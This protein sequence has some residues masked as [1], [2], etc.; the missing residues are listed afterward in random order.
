MTRAV[1][2]SMPRLLLSQ[3]LAEKLSW[4]LRERLVLTRRLA[5]AIQVLHR[6]GQT[7]RSLDPATITL[8]EQFQPQLGPPAGP[9][10]FGGDQSD[11]EFCPPELA[12]SSVVELPAEIEVAAAILRQRGIALDPRRID[13]YQLGVLLCQLL[14]GEPFLNYLYSPTCK[15]KVPPMTRA[16]LN[17]CLGESPAGPLADCDAMVAAL[18]D[19]IRQ[20]PQDS[21]TSSLETPPSGSFVISPGN[22]PPHGKAVAL[23]AETPDGEKLPFQ[24][25]GHFQIVSQIGSGG[26]GDVYR[27]YDASLD[28]YVAIK[29]LAEAL[30]RDKE[31][32][33]RFSAEATAVAKLSHPNVVP[34]Y[35]I[36]QDARRHF[37]AMQFIEGQSLAERLA[38]D[39][40]LPVDE[41][42][43]IIEQC[44][45]GLGA[46]HAQGLIHRDV[47]P[48]NILLERAS[49]RAVLVDFGLVRHLNAESRMTATGVVMGTVDYLAPEQARGRA[50]DG[51][52]DIY[53]VG[54]MFY[55]LLGGR[56]P[57]IADSPT[58]MIFQHAYETPFPLKKAAPDVPQSLVDVTARM[59]A[60]EPAERYASCDAVLADLRAFREGRPVEAASLSKVSATSNTPADELP[61]DWEP[62]RVLLP[63]NNPWQRA[64]DWAATMFRRHAPQYVQEM[65]DTTQQM[66]A[67]VAHYE[68]RCKRL[69]DL[70]QE[71][72][73]IESDLSQQINA[74]LAVAASKHNG[75]T[76]QA[77]NNEHE[78][79]VVALRSQRDVQRQQVEE[80]ERQLGKAS[81]TLASLHSQQN[82]L[83]SRL[84][85]AEARR[86]LEGGPI[87]RT[88]RQRLVQIAIVACF[89]ALLGSGLVALVPGA[90]KRLYAPEMRPPEPPLPIEVPESVGERGFRGSAGPSLAVGGLAETDFMAPTEFPSQWRSHRAFAKISSPGRVVFPTLPVSAYVFEADVTS[91]NPAGKLTFHLGDRDNGTALVMGHMWDHV[92]KDV[93]QIRCRLFAC[94]PFG[95]NWSGGHDYEPGTRL[96]L[97]IVVPDGQNR[98]LY[99]NGVPTLCAAGV[100]ADLTLT[101]VAEP[102]ADATIHRCTLRKLDENDVKRLGLQMPQRRIS[103]DFDVAAARLS[104]ET[105]AL[106]L[107][108]H[109]AEAFRV[110]TTGTVMNWISPGEFV[111]GSPHASYEQF[112]KGA[113]RVRFT[114][115]YWIGRYQVM[116]GEWEGLMGDNPSRVQ[117][118]PCLPVNW[119]SWVDAARFCRKLTDAEKQ[120]GRIPEGYEYR[121]P[122]EA[123]WEYACLAGAAGASPPS[124][125]S[126]SAKLSKELTAPVWLGELHQE[127]PNAWGLCGMLGSVPE[128]CAD[129]WRPY[130]ADG[131][132]R[133]V[134]DRF[135]A[136]GVDVDCFVV[137]GGPFD[138]ITRFR[139]APM[140]AGDYRGFR[141]VLGPELKLW[142]GGQRASAVAQSRQAFIIGNSPYYQTLTDM[143]RRKG[144]TVRRS[145]NTQ[146][147]ELLPLAKGHLLLVET[148][149]GI[150]IVPL[151]VL[152][153]VFPGAS[154]GLKTS[155][156]IVNIG[157]TKI[158][159]VDFSPPLKGMT[160]DSASVGSVERQV[161]VVGNSPYYETLTEMAQ[162]KGMTVVS[163]FNRNYDTW[164]KAAQGHILLVETHDGTPV[165]PLSF[166]KKFYPN[167]VDGLKTPDGIATVENTRIV[168]VDFSRLLH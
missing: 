132:T 50:V 6:Q 151:P 1:A 71:A 17:S 139:A 160:D 141:L 72:R 102:N 19:L 42:V 80:L 65:Q 76:A 131:Q 12:Q 96:Q 33:R 20:L 35:F 105:V 158:V 137:R 116:Q 101:I 119:I 23:P 108:A 70:L 130:P 61:V 97:K 4:S 115:G 136:G 145:F 104:R 94:Q 60:K 63:S 126:P 36:G 14:T 40:R 89:F 10:R 135:E 5:L 48:G 95:V 106:G 56:L 15:A 128:W 31:F 77:R 167:A 68:R 155:D 66:D 118:S 148:H 166:L 122:T 64:R 161:F 11:P 142:D 120:H 79:D 133:V 44:L 147:D 82:V 152:D 114:K 103:P 51:R 73:G 45:A 74:Q 57:F 18:D 54:V 34:I 140:V 93:K 52:A 162:R 3:L 113:Q 7:H 49:G 32:V 87:R 117:G 159:F 84:Q 146:Y 157:G 164:L 86:H 55:E 123:E 127:L 78:R 24:Q 154:K 81:A 21:R 53:S 134:L 28:R 90:L 30:A 144:M 85:A 46:A 29:V 59:M 38:R 91:R 8:G 100:A 150:P 27:G 111:M 143:T 39:K 168:F 98:W 16:L 138:A 13:V 92:D 99:V 149:A 110:P 112:G 37:F 75:Q 26:M 121:L 156:G 83:K 58:A 124:A 107:A 88:S 153:R 2:D 165:V 69:A 9:R 22:T 67:A 163:T 47:K 43:T 41:A 62:G 129:A 109:Q 25:L 125:I